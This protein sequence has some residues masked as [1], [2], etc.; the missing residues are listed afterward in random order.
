MTLR[1]KAIWTCFT[2]IE[3]LVVI[4][5][6]AI[7]AAM[8]L[9]ALASAREKAR[10]SAC[11]NDLNQIAKGTESYSADYGG[12]FPCSPAWGGSPG[13][14][15]D[16]NGAITADPTTNLGVGRGSTDLGKVTDLNGQVVYAGASSLSTTTGAGIPANARI[17]ASPITDLRTVYCGDT[18]ASAD[19]NQRNHRKGTF[20]MT[21]AGLGYLLQC[22]YSPDIRS[23]YCPSTGGSMPPGNNYYNTCDT[24]LYA[25][26]SLQD[27]QRAAGGFDHNA[28]AYGD[29]ESKVNGSPYGTAAYFYYTNHVALQSDYNYRN[30]PAVIPRHNNLF[31]N[32]D[33]PAKALLGYTR[34]RIEIAAGCPLFKTSKQLGGRAIVSDSFSRSPYGNSVPWPT[35]PRSVGN[36]FYAHRDGYNVLFGDWSARWVGD[37]DLRMMWWGPIWEASF[38]SAWSAG[39]FQMAAAFSATN[40]SVASRWEWTSVPSG[41]THCACPNQSGT[42]EVWHFL[43]A[44]AG[45]DK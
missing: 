41:A 29:W 11:L 36:G 21:A 38:F 42:A 28:V 45:L 6:I 5:I 22:G 15:K 35:D 13:H 1:L 18:S 25:A 9:P 17:L 10:R 32:F 20:N 2:L 16:T 26:T 34:P 14:C 23:L 33:A 43:D 7:L 27:V 37:A 19:A 39:P 8:L 12:Y 30:M 24:R 3:L 44:T 40:L 4:A 31:G